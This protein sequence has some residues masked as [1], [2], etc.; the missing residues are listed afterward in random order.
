MS[1]EPGTTSVP[2]S[3]ITLDSRPNS[4]FAVPLDDDPFFASVVARVV[5]FVAIEIASLEP[6][7]ST[8]ISRSLCA[9]RPS[10][11]ASDHMTPDDTIT[12]K[13]EMSHRSGC[14][15]SARRIGLANASPTIEVELIR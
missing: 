6:S 13:V 12:R 3:V 15:S 4:N 5:V 1:P 8:M 11:V 10:L 7:E 9:S 14:S 2:S